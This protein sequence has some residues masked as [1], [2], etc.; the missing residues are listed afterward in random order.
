[1]NWM[2]NGNINWQGGDIGFLN[3]TMTNNGVF[4]ATGD[5]NIFAFGD[6]TPPPSSI[7]NVAGG[8][9]SKTDGATRTVIGDFID[10][11]NLGTVSAESGNLAFNGGFVQNGGLTQLVFANIGSS[12]DMLMTQQVTLM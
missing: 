12:S 8:V 3:V 5:N 2:Q 4:S 11:T 6:E 7:V 10:F 1:M 9:W